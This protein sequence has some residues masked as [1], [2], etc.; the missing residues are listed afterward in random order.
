MNQTYPFYL[1]LSCI[2]ISI[3]ILG[4]L[5]II[6]E[7][8]LIPMV[9][10]LLIAILLM[11]L[12]RFME[13]KLRFPRSL[14]SILASLLALAIIGGVIYV[15]SLQVAKL[16]NDWPSF[17]KQF[18]DLIDDLQGWIS[19]TFGVK[20]KDQLLYLNDTAKKSISTGTAILEKALKSIGYVLMLTGFTFLFTLFF[21]L[22][23]THLI[24][25]LVAS[26]SETYHTTVFEIIDNIQFMVK[27]Y[28]VGL[29]LQM[30]IVTI[31]S[32]IA[33][34]IIGVKYNFMLAILT[35]ILNILPY[36]GIFTAL[37]IGALI[38]FATAGVSHVL[39]IVIAIVV[40]HAIDGN[41]IMPR[42]VGSKVKINSLIVIIGLVIGEMLWGIAGMLLTIPVLAIMKIV[43]DRVEG[44][45]SWGFLMGEDDDVPVFKS[46]FD[47]YFLVKRSEIEKVEIIPD[48]KDEPKN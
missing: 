45:Q 47:K 11:P 41:I 1:K 17:Q 36:I 38:T 26:F 12:S 18:T 3:V 8:I 22:Y 40:I 42:V 23:R 13:K 44:L 20:R 14:S 19:R 28:L 27:K 25:F 43:F 24:K 32:L 48:P 6:G 31:L 29:F 35:G 37:L 46:T 5:A 33:Y 7:Q 21:L 9:L 15:L 10:G 4:F 39:F 34:T 16:A 2:L 30:L